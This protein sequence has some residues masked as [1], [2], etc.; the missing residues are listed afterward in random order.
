MWKRY[1][2]VK[3]LLFLGL[4]CYLAAGI[5]NNLILARLSRPAEVA[6]PLARPEV[7]SPRQVAQKTLNTYSL[8]TR[9]NVFNSR[10]TGESAAGEDGAGQKSS[11]PLKRAEL[12]AK[13]I[14]TVSGSRENSFAIIEDGSTKTQQL[15]QIDDTLLE[16]AR[17][18][19]ISRCKVV[20]L[21]DGARE[22]LECPE[23]GEPD[24]PKP[25]PVALGTAPPGSGEPGGGVRKVS[26]SE[27]LV[28]EGEVESALSNLNQLLTQI[29]IVPNFQDGKPDGFKVFAIKP[30]SIF[31]KLGLENG[32]VIQRV[33]G[34]D[35]STPEKAF[36]VFQDLRNEK[37]LSV[38][39]VR[40][41]SPQ[42][43]RY[44]IR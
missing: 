1:L 27:Y 29:R 31:A 5:G 38:D 9:R 18:I 39:V 35:L 22:V 26:E 11:A 24:K 37:S 40:K 6:R 21:R 4:A 2:W 13:L 7:R 10:Y 28:D 25:A 33:N 36:Q 12:N 34:R 43:L 15:Y 19:E 42:S 32:D 3:N 30:D 16:Q 44:Q 23:E 14:G 8:I 41:G 20:L 17:I